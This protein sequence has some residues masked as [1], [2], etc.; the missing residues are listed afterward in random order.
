MQKIKEFFKKYQTGTEYG[1]SFLLTAGIIQ[2]MGKTLTREYL[3]AVLI[4]VAA[5]AIVKYSFAHCNKRRFKFAAF[6]SV[7]FSL[8]FWFGR[9]VVYQSIILEKFGLLD[10]PNIL[11]FLVIFTLATIC[12]LSFID[13]KAFKPG[14][15]GGKLFKKKN[16]LFCSLI[17]LACW[18]PI[19]LAFF[20]G[21]ISVDSAVQIRQVVGERG[22]SN[23][24]PVLHTLFLSGPINLGYGITGDLTAGIALATIL[25]MILLAVIFGYTVNW[26]TEKT[27]KKWISVAF[28]IFFALS[29]VVA[30]YAVT[31]WKDILFSA[32]FMLLIIKLIDFINVYKRE[33]QINFAK[34]VPILALVLLVG[35]LRNGGA[36]IILTLGIAMVIYFKKSRKIF[37]LSFAGVLAITLVVQGPGYKALNIESSPFMESMSVPAQQLGYLAQTNKLDDEA[38]QNLSKYADVEC[39]K[40]KYSPMNADPAKNCFDYNVV[41]EDKAGLISVWVDNLTKHFKEY[42]KSYV[43]HTYSYW[44]IYGDMWVLDITH[45]HDDIWLKTD[46]TDV[47]LLGEPIRDGIADVEHG[48]TVSSWLGWMNNVGVLF[49]GVLFVLLVI[50]YQKRYKLLIPLVCILI[51]MASLLIASPV[52]WIFR[53]VYSLILILP[54]L[55]TNC[56]ISEKKGGT[57][58]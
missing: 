44:Y 22:W 36:L 13:E 47:S 31:M 5:R 1:L 14:K 6:F 4:F 56:F 25:Q 9:K 41:E 33:E 43:L 11:T 48:L 7:P 39:L 37:A 18:L 15:T 34:I 12:A 49:W 16:W 26:I 29:P 57:K 42:I 55:I 38:V 2:A 17:I 19:F 53:Y 35:F 23:W 8:I 27:T 32:I 58:K 52:S 51:Y 30:C 28:L 45:T 21:L 54:V 10:I 24:H 40:T 46:Y 20:P 50:I 3:L